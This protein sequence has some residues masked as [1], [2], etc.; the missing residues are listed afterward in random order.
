MVKEPSELA[1][2]EFELNTIN[3]VFGAAFGAY[4]GVLMSEG[5]LTNGQMFQLTVMLALL[6]SFILNLRAVARSISGV[7]YI[8][9]KWPYNL[10]LTLALGAAIQFMAYGLPED[11]YKFTI[12]F[13]GWVIVLVLILGV[14][15]LRNRRSRD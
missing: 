8:G 11:P 3:F 14:G 10:T 5:N 15:I 9:F 13:R 1:E 6:T 12:F 2:F 4:V 7:D